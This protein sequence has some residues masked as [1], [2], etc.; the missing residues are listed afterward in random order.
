MT[1]PKILRPLWIDWKD[2]VGVCEAEHSYSDG[3]KGPT[4]ILLLSGGH[5]VEWRVSVQEAI[6]TTK[7]AK[8][9]TKPAA[10]PKTYP[11]RP[12]H[13]KHET[14]FDGVCAFCGARY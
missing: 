7:V 5:A 13:C 8:G 11:R 6:E 4:C 10:A 1:I 9:L 14:R 12:E 3:T 2:V